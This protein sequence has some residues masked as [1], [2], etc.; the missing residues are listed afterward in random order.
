M[1]GVTAANLRFG[2]GLVPVSGT[3]CAFCRDYHRR[4]NHPGM[5]RH[6]HHVTVNRFDSSLSHHS[7]SQILHVLEFAPLDRFALR[8]RRC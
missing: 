3:V 7:S 8:L 4:N 6:D 5:S 1:E 2:S